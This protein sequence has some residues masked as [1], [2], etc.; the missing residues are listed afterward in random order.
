MSAL[1]SLVEQA[2]AVHVEWRI[3]RVAEATSKLN[4]RELELPVGW[5]VNPE[6]RYFT[7][8]EQGRALFTNPV[9]LKAIL[10]DHYNLEDCDHVPTWDKDT[11]AVLEMLPPTQH[12]FAKLVGDIFSKCAFPDKMQRVT[13]AKRDFARLC[14]M[15]D[16]ARKFTDAEDSINKLRCDSKIPA[17]IPACVIQGNT[18]YHDKKYK[19][20]VD[21]LRICGVLY[22]TA[23]SKFLLQAGQIM[24]QISYCLLSA[25]DFQGCLRVAEH[26]LYMYIMCREEVDWAF[27]SV[28]NVMGQCYRAMGVQGLAL[29]H[30]IYCFEAS[31]R[32]S[33]LVAS[34]KRHGATD[35]YDIYTPLWMPKIDNLFHAD[36]ALCIGAC[37]LSMEEKDRALEFFTKAFHLYTKIGNARE[38][39]TAFGAI[40]EACYEQDMYEASVQFAEAAYSI[41]KETDNKK[42]QAFDLTYLAHGH[43]MCL[44][45]R[46]AID[47]FE[48]LYQLPL[49]SRCKKNE[50]SNI[51][52]FSDCL[53]RDKQTAKAI[54]GLSLIKKYV[55]DDQKKA[56]CN[57]ILAACFVDEG[58]LVEA[59]K[60]MLLAQGYPSD[61]L[62][63]KKARV[64]LMMRDLALRLD[65]E[66]LKATIDLC[67][68]FSAAQAKKKKQSSGARKGRAN[69][70]A[71]KD[72]S[73]QEWSEGE[74]CVCLAA[75][76]TV[77]FSPCFHRCVCLACSAS[78]LANASECPMC[79]VKSDAAHEVLDDG[80]ACA[81]C[82]ADLR[83]FAVAPCFHMQFCEACGPSALPARCSACGGEARGTH[84][85]FS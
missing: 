42:H 50:V 20:A 32:F 51:L 73:A 10:G 47:A 68:G 65:E 30:Y 17:M 11:L 54:A 31:E 7:L 36:K 43:A 28:L 71:G 44:N 40:A 19:E 69:T 72:P 83:T 24:Q 14:T 66:A 3:S 2:D 13:E 45:V 38:S 16:L 84:K 6:F 78:I 22:L 1:G 23:G 35:M 56:W 59:R 49:A 74:C 48:K 15:M 39:R 81:R 62:A 76:A 70:D 55:H 27:V 21:H 63:A 29:A 58:K 52:M 77:A 5:S 60:H 8:H 18:L 80:A 85:V 46:E 25:K 75:S 34:E 33:S 79:R 64:E 26:A 12:C 82:N 67:P 61:F 41:S 37:L 9:E 53:Q 4:T 57:L